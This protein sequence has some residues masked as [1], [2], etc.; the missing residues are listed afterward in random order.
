M[1]C[2]LLT[3][4]GLTIPPLAL[5][6]STADPLIV[7]AHCICQETAISPP[8]RPSRPLAVS[9]FAASQAIRLIESDLTVFAGSRLQSFTHTQGHRLGFEIRNIHLESLLDGPVCCLR[10][11]VLLGSACLSTI[12]SCSHNLP[13]LEYFALSPVI[14]SEL[15]EKPSCPGTFPPDAQAAGYLCLVCSYIFSTNVSFAIVWRS[16]SCLRIPRWTRYKYSFTLVSWRRTGK[17]QRVETYRTY[18]A[19]HTKDRTMGGQ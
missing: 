2:I 10:K 3:F 11:L 16:G 7:F 8:R 1:L 12:T 5:P 15:R 19:S 14:V 4:T 13:T 6:R 18:S 9:L 17:E